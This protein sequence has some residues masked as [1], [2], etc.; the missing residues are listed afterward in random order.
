MIKRICFI[1][2]RRQKF[3]V[4]TT[5]QLYRRT[6]WARTRWGNSR[7]IKLFKISYYSCFKIG[8]GCKN[9]ILMRFVAFTQY[10]IQ[11][12]LICP[13]KLTQPEILG[14]I[15]ISNCR[16]VRVSGRLTSLASFK[17]QRIRWS[18]NHELLAHPFMEIDKVIPT[19]LR[20]CSRVYHK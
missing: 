17:K 3:L 9:L 20:V 16:K 12:Q 6:R 2:I 13:V 10:R 18:F 11:I 14:K 7:I 1:S 5:G 19:H 4:I 15:K 8:Q